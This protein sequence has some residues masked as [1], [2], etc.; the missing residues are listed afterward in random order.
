MGFWCQHLFV[1]VQTVGVNPSCLAEVGLGGLLPLD[2]LNTTVESGV[3]A[4][5]IFPVYN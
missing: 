4:K 3:S 1:S 2:T 5:G